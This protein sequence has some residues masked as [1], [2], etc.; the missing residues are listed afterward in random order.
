MYQCL[1]RLVMGTCVTN[2]C[3]SVYGPNI[4]RLT[5]TGLKGQKM[6]QND[7]TFVWLT[8]YLTNYT[9]YDCVFWNTCVPNCTH[10]YR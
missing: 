5:V 1:C 3:A 6:V 2:K 8:L 10:V 4:M 9:A 7:K